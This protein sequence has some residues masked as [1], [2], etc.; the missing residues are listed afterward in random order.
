MNSVTRKKK[1]LTLDWNRKLSYVS[2][3]ERNKKSIWTTRSLFSAAIVFHQV[4]V[5]HSHRPK[6]RNNSLIQDQKSNKYIANGY[7]N[8]VRVFKREAVQFLMAKNIAV[9]HLLLEA[10]PAVQTWTANCKRDRK[11]LVTWQFVVC[12]ENH[13]AKGLYC[14]ISAWCWQ[15]CGRVVELFRQNILCQP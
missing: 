9:N 3:A 5:H 1:I 10:L 14:V 6:N 13:D 15:V 11:A 7:K 4:E 2:T 8:Q 12:L